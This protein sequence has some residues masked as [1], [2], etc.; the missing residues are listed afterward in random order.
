MAVSPQLFHFDGVGVRLAGERWA[1]GGR[2]G[3]VVLLHGGG[4]TRHSWKRT[5]ERLAASGRTAVALDARGHGDSEWHP[6]HDYTL[7]GFVG[8]LIAYV[9]TLERPPALVGA[10]LGGITALIAAGE[11]PGLASALVLVDVV[12]RVEPKGVARIRDFMTA[13]PEG[14]SSLEEVADA[15]AA[16]NPLRPRPQRLDGLRKNV[17]Q[18]ADGRWYWH[19][20]PAFMR[21]DDE[22]QRHIDPERLRVAASHLTIPTLIVRGAQSDIVSDGGIA[23]MLQL[24]PHAQTVDVQAA[25]H[26]VA[27][28]DNDVFAARLEAFLNQLD[29]DTGRA[30][31]GAPAE[32]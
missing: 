5:A 12:V 26:M 4:Q 21:I 7:D 32:R 6:T 15:I 20:D 13:N 24:V 16:Y 14:F 11:H 18:H 25:G 9:A 8:D 19:W 22:P 30:G 28:D 31:D 2:G 27:G 29:T 1:G 3:V 17:R 10:S 23:D